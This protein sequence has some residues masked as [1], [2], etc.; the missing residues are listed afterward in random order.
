M[1]ILFF[2]VL[3]ETDLKQ[4]N[5]LL[6][7]KPALLALCPQLPYGLRMIDNRPAQ[8]MTQASIIL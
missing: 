6:R 2:E 1:D 4:Y 3:V 5:D 8:T 7:A